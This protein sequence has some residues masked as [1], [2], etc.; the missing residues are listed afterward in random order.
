MINAVHRRWL[1][2]PTGLAI[3]VTLANAI[4]PVLID[5][6]AYLAYARHIAAHPLD[7]YGFTIYWYSAPEPAMEVLAPPLVPYWLALGIRLFGDEPAALKLWLF[8]FVWVFSRSLGELLRR[9]ARGTEEV[10][11]PLIVLSPAVL[12]MVNL[13]LDI[14]ASALGL[15]AL[16][17]LARGG[18]ASLTRRWIAALAAGILAGLALQTKYTA[19]LVPP[20]LLWYGCTHQRLRHAVLA[21]GIGAVL[22]AG[23]EALLFLKYGRSH[24]LYHLVEHSAAS[25]NWLRDKAALLPPLVGHLGCLAVGVGLF[26]G[27]T[28][29]LSRRLLSLSGTLWCLGV[30]L[31]VLLPYHDTILVHGKE[32]GQ[33]KLALASVIWRTAGTAILLSGAV[34]A[35]MLWSPKRK[36]LWNSTLACASGFIGR[37]T[38]ADSLFVVGWVFLELAGYFV[39]TPFPAARRVIGLTIALGVLAARASNR[40]CRTRPER[41]PP[42]W[43]LP[44]GASVGILVAALDT[45]DAFP[46]KDLANRAAELVH[47]TAPASRVWFVGHWGFQYYCERAGM[48]PVVPGQ[49]VLEPGDCLVLPLYP[50]DADFYRPYPGAASI[51][52][53]ETAVVLIAILVWD[54]WLSAQTVPNF[55]GGTEPVQGRDHPRLRVGVYRVVQPWQTPEKTR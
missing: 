35:M 52:P 10:A 33:V 30:T 21:V 3:I 9:F 17:V 53:P 7:P 44:F 5:D 24:F 1:A 2:G 19:L 41:R 11:L 18:H 32:P 22:F 36:P 51:H 45:F 54:D 37:C 34:C 4:K 31:I 38:S 40:V 55:Y 42:C 6:T 43:L 23:W 13:M 47:K 46:E 29:G 27:G 14:P 16:A 25:G 49:T 50:D 15:A 8:P 12:P 20:L 48:I 39:L 28:L 26:A